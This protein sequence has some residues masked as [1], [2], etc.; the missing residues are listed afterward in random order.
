MLRSLFTGLSALTLAQTAAA[1]IVVSSYSMVDGAPLHGAYYDNLYNGN[2]GPDGWLSGGTG[3]L[4]DGVTSASVV[5]GY[6]AWAP[7]VMWDA[8]SPVILFDLGESYRLSRIT[9]Y[10]KYYAQAAVYM[11]GAMSLR[12]S[13]DGLHFGSSQL[14]T[15]SAAERLPGA[16]N[17]DGVFEL[18]NGSQAAGRYV[19][20]SLHNGPEQRWLALGEV[21]FEGSPGGPVQGVPEPGSAALALL[22]LLGLGLQ[23]RRA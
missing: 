9:S 7:Y 5:A 22:A 10:F 4:T 13:S 16:D 23:R 6:G 14:R 1:G 2:H 20:L 8:Q 15:L 18:L 19:E 11:P 3:D 12:F 21:V 17:S